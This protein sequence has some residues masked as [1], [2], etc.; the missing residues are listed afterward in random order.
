MKHKLT[1]A[2]AFAA[3]LIGALLGRYINPQNAFAQAVQTPSA[4]KEVRAQGFT[5]VDPAGHVI[6][7]L[8]W[9][10]PTTTELTLGNGIVLPATPR[11]VLQDA[12]GR[13]IWSPSGD[14]VFRQ[15]GTR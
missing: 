6:G 5:I 8:T 1:I 3:G 10:L 13:D 9:R 12:S 4:T 14:G 7:T 2:L 11:I 15:L